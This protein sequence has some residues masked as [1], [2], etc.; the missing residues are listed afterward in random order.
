MIPKIKHEAEVL[1]DKAKQ[2]AQE[3][4]DKVK[5][6]EAI[7]NVRYDICKSCDELIELTSTCKKCGCFMAV[8]TYV[9]NASCPINKWGQILSITPRVDPT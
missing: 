8:K 3:A 2:L 9:P 5:L 7:R 6:P 1:A 4:F